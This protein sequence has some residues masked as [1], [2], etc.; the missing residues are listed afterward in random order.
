MMKSLIRTKRALG[1]FTFISMLVLTTTSIQAVKVQK[2]LETA[3]G[4]EKMSWNPDL[5]RN[6]KNLNS[7]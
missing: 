5:D 4:I 1:A 3:K 7:K 2:F 6:T